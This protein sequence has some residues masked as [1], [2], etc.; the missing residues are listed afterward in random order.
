LQRAQAPGEQGADAAAQAPGIR[1]PLG[2]VRDLCGALGD[3]SA[4]LEVA[5]QLMLGVPSQFE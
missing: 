2:G 1:H 4:P 5:G 3:E